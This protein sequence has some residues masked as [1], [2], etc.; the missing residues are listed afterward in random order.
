MPKLSDIINMPTQ[1]AGQEILICTYWGKN[2][3]VQVILL[4][5]LCMYSL[6]SFIP[7]LY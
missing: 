5:N 6:A 7:E 3:T 1:Y 2:P 4:P